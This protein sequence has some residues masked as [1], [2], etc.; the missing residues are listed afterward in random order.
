MILTLSMTINICYCRVLVSGTEVEGYAKTEGAWIL[1]MTRNQYS[2]N[3]VSECA[4]KCDSETLFTCRHVSAHT[5][6]F[7][8]VSTLILPQ[9]Y[10]IF[11]YS[12][13]YRFNYRA[14]FGG[15]RFRTSGL[16]KNLVRL[17][18][19]AAA[20]HQTQWRSKNQTRHWSRAACTSL[21]HS[22]NQKPEFE[23]DMIML[24]SNI[25]RTLKLCFHRA[26]IYIEKDQECWTAAANSKTE[27][28]LRRTS[29]ALYEK[30]GLASLLW[31]LQ[32]PQS[33]HRI[34]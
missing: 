17:L 33:L 20:R 18:L 12:V 24:S 32:L 25:C 29:T 23:S 3:S 34:F 19:V 8:Y 14:C 16:S 30:K 1:S 26:F 31:V 15:Q 2:V 10:K 22:V 28:V 4:V 6:W 9:F 21:T 11:F 7:Y 5:W 13:F 27:H